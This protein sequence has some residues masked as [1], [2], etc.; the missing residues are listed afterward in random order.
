VVSIQTERPPRT[1]VIAQNIPNAF[2]QRPQWVNWKHAWDGTKWTKHPYNPRTGRK[3]DTTDLLTWSTFVDV[4]AGYELEDYDGIG[5]VFCSGDPFV[6]IDLDNCR[7]PE[8]EIISEQAQEIID[9]FRQK[10][11]EISPSGRG[12]HIITRGVQ[13]NGRRKGDLEVYGQERFFT[14]TGVTI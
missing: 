14:F 9:S 4:L 6:G 5:F 7:D 2:T 1:E 8:T 13:R 10:Y 12:V 11:V 3:A